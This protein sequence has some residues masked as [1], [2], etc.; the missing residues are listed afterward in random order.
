MVNGCQQTQYLIR[1][2]GLSNWDTYNHLTFSAWRFLTINVY[3]SLVF[4]WSSVTV[5]PFRRRLLCWKNIQANSWDLEKKRQGFRDPSGISE[6]YNAGLE[7]W[8]FI[9]WCYSLWVSGKS[10]DFVRNPFLVLLELALW[11]L[12]FALSYFKINMMLLEFIIF[13][14]GWDGT[15]R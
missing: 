11:L 4:R 10:I 1:A 5:G 2:T 12:G 15:I 14:Y 8:G 7:G 6:G 13:I 3:H 9:L